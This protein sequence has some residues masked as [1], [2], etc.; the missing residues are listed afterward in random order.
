MKHTTRNVT[1]TEKLGEKS[2]AKLRGGEV[3]LLFGELG[4]GKTAFTRGLI[5]H[6]LPGIRVLSPTFIIVRHYKPGKNYIKN[7]YH[8]DLYRVS[9]EKEIES[10]GFTEYLFKPSTIIVVEWPDLL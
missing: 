5:R 9:S 6:F 7:I 8:V 10:V 2:A 4:S 1:E 3:V